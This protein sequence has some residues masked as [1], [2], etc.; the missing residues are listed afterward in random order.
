MSPFVIAPLA[1]SGF[2][3]TDI[4][5][6]ITQ[7]CSNSS[8]I[9]SSKAGVIVSS[10][11]FFRALAAESDFLFDTQYLRLVDESIYSFVQ[12]NNPELTSAIA[13]GINQYFP[14]LT[15]LA[16][17]V[18]TLGLFTADLLGYDGYN[19]TNFESLLG[20]NL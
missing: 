19:I 14:L 12:N 15:S 7:G 2:V 17:E 18:E 11:N 5:M 13:C 4:T 1:F 3:N 6:R 16:G 20:Y 10:C 9:E 8:F